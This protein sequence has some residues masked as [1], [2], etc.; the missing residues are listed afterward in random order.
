MFNTL[1]IGGMILIAAI[2]FG[3]A[4][5]DRKFDKQRAANMRYWCAPRPDRAFFARPAE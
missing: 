2:C 5:Y 3:C 4:Y 1:M